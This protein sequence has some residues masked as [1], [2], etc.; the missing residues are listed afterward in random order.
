MKE[1]FKCKKTLSLD[2]FYKHSQMKDGH[3]NKCK[4][5]NKKDVRENY[6]VNIEHFKE[7]EKK[8][9]MLPHR[10]KLR[11]E[12]SKTEGGKI[13]KAKTNKKYNKFYREER[14]QWTKKDRII[15]PKK[16]RA[17]N[18]VNHAIRGGFLIKPQHCEECLLDKKLHGHHCDYNKP[19]DVMWLCTQCHADWHKNNKAID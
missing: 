12:Y 5:C 10:V 11:E 14:Y 17:R 13:S 2:N 9:A 3:V 1:C 18:L 7:Y 8:R 19:L 16:H 15:N 4:E 6:K